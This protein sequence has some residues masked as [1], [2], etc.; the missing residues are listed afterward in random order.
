MCTGIYRQT[1]RRESSGWTYQIVTS[2]LLVAGPSCTAIGTLE[3]G[4]RFYNEFSWLDLNATHAETNQVST[5]SVPNTLCLCVNLCK[6]CYWNSGPI[7]PR[8]GRLH[9]AQMQI[10]VAAPD[11]ATNG[12]CWVTSC[13]GMDGGY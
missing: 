1:V 5:T 4:V 11:K 8:Q 10:I 2:R 7:H 13:P 12:G 3:L 9:T 6:R